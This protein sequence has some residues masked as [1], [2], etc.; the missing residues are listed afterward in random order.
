MRKSSMLMLIVGLILV[1]S[2][3]IGWTQEKKAIFGY[4]MDYSKIY[5]I[6]SFDWFNGAADYLTLV[7]QKG[8]ILGHKVEI[9]TAD[10]ANEPQRGLEL[11]EQYKSQG[12]MFFNF[13]STACVTAV[14]PRVL[15]DKI[16]MITPQHGRSDAADGTVFPYVFIGTPNYWTQ[17]ASQIEFILNQEGGKLQGKKIGYNYID[18]P[19]G[20]EPLPI[21]KKL[22]AELKFQLM[23]F[24]YPPPGTEQTAAW[25]QI[26]RAKP[27]WIILW[28]IRHVS[29]AQA[30]GINY[31]LNRILA[32]GWL[33]EHEVGRVG[34]DKLKGALSAQVIVTGRGLPIVEEVYKEVQA[35]GKGK[36]EEAKFACLFYNQGM[37][38]SIL[39]EKAVRT[40]LEKFGEPLTGEK[41]KNAL[42]TL[43]NFD[44]FG[45]SPPITFTKENHEGAKAIR[46]AEW[47]G[48][49]WVPKTDWFTTKFYSMVHDFVKE[50]SAKFKADQK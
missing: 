28:G 7:N 6:A 13:Y 25:T 44:P 21:F 11:Y 23:E 8:G 17:A 41:L 33:A 35:K 16:V 4:P 20:R 9:L 22:A 47:D 39:F 34:K 1:M 5:G 12:A 15:K 48:A 30:I 40:A 31:P 3:Q 36:G 24:P 37:L 45:L 18:T 29:L 26:R 14:L 19:W 27:D 49:K 43:T 42:E 50:Q 2:C 32:D 46:V 38:C 10:H